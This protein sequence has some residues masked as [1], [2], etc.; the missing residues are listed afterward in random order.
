MPEQ[1]K[2][3]KTEQDDHDQI[4][5]HLGTDVDFN[6]RLDSSDDQQRFRDLILCREKK[7]DSNC[8]NVPWVYELRIYV[9]KV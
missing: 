9:F 4:K 7:G 8:E 6:S 3:G 1:R 2:P 5:V